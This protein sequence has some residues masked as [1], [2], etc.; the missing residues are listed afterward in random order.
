MHSIFPF[1]LIKGLNVR[2]LE[3]EIEWNYEGLGIMLDLQTQDTNKW[4]SGVNL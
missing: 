4:S 2:L 3:L 1:W